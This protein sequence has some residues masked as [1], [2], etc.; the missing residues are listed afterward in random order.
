MLAF[1]TATM[2]KIS[3]SSTRMYIQRVYDYLHKYF[4]TEF[5][6]ERKS[7]IEQEISIAMQSATN[8]NVIS[9]FNVARYCYLWFSLGPNFDNSP[10]LF[11]KIDFL[12]ELDTDESERIDELF[13]FVESMK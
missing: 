12:F 1:D 2:E 3:E 11:G 6:L 8:I 7:S 10:Q 4:Y 5:C 13:T 9:E